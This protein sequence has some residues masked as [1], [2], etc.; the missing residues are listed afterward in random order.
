MCQGF[1]QNML[2]LFK[3]ITSGFILIC[4][5]ICSF[6][7]TK[8]CIDLFSTKKL[9][10]RIVPRG[11]HQEYPRHRTFRLKLLTISGVGRTRLIRCPCRLSPC[12]SHLQSNHPLHGYRLPATFA[13]R[14]Y[15]MQTEPYIF[16]A[17][18]AF[19]LKFSH[20]LR[21]QV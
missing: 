1:S 14:H 10:P 13:H 19:T 5:F 12:F 4:L 7:R 2:F 15:I 9:L 17:A 6:F 20:R 21:N 16:F 8:Y 3:K 18:V 11:N